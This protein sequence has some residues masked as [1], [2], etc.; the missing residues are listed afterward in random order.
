MRDTSWDGPPA[1]SP[2]TAVT[3]R[4]GAPASW[5]RKQPGS[6]VICPPHAR[7]GQDPPDVQPRS[8]SRHGRLRR[9]LPRGASP[10]PP[11]D[12][13]PRLRPALREGQARGLRVP[14]DPDRTDGFD[15]P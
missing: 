14:L 5:P 2:E 6:V 4:P 10:L 7:E 9:L 8:R 12:G 11:D 15:L 1:P 3:A 13:E